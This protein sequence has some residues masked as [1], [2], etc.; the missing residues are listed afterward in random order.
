MGLQ[1]AN[2][3]PVSWCDGCGV[4]TGLPGAGWS[5]PISVERWS[6]CVRAQ[7]KPGW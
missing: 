3:S 6:E 5:L 4:G 7:Q 2:S 1:E